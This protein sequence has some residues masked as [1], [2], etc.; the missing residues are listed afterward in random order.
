MEGLELC[1]VMSLCQA[2]RGLEHVAGMM[3]CAI[4]NM[5]YLQRS[6]ILWS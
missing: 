2:V 1:A 6:M 5:R 4:G 3:V